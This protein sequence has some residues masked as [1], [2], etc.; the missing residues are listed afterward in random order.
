MG[1]DKLHV[2]PKQGQI[3]NVGIL[4]HSPYSIALPRH[5]IDL[6]E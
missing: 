6:V 5:P 3:S 1:W 4:M 2:E